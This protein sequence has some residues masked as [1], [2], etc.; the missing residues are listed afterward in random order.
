V[1]RRLAPPGWLKNAAHKPPHAGR[2]LRRKPTMP[3]FLVHLLTMENG[4]FEFLK[5]ARPPR[6]EPGESP[7][8]TD[9]APGLY[10]AVAP[11]ERK[12]FHI[13]IISLAQT[14]HLNI[15]NWDARSTKNKAAQETKQERPLS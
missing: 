15:R 11:H 8:F 2:P 3:A 9:A 4:S 12:P 10:P 5:G 6:L 7:S 1:S 14:L 13:T